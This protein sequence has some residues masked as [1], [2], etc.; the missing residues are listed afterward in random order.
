MQ[1]RLLIA[2]EVVEFLERLPS[3][4]RR[5]LRNGIGAI[6]LD[7]NGLSDAEDYDETGR[8]LQITILGEYAITY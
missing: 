3:K 8:T 7:P 1:Y 5:T 4:T 6:G 2:I